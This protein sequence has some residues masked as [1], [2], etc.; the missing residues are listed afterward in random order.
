[1]PP[2]LGTRRALALGWA[3][4]LALLLALPAA[5]RSADHKRPPHHPNAATLKQQPKA[6][7]VP[8][9]K[10]PV[11]APH[12]KQDRGPVLRVV[13]RFRGEAASD[14][15]LAGMAPRRKSLMAVASAKPDPR[16][17]VRVRSSIG[18]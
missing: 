7:R 14:R 18:G 9:P 11:L 10:T 13:Q 12:A 3:G 6:K 8:P 17:V 5:A 2:H 16:P 1:M 4:L 15:L